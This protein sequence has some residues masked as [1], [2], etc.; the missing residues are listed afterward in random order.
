MYLVFWI[1][2]NNI[3]LKKSLLIIKNLVI[4][5]LKNDF[6][7]SFISRKISRKNNILNWKFVE[8]EK[9]EFKEL[10]TYRIFF[11]RINIP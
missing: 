11:S 10:C 3:L 2:R 6:F 7:K 4:F 5:F 8:K 1:L 9:N